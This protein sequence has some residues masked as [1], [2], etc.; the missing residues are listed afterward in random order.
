MKLRTAKRER[1][2]M[3]LSEDRK[4]DA[5][6][7]ESVGITRKTLHKWKQRPEFSARVEDLTRIWSERALKKGLARRE[8]RLAVLEDQH[9]RLLAVIEA[10]AADPDMQTIPGGSTGL[11]FRTYKGLGSGEHARIVE[12]YAVDVATIRELRGIQEQFA[13]ELGQVV[14]KV[15]VTTRKPYQTTEELE[16]EL[17]LLLAKRQARRPEDAPC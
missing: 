4:T 7:A 12:E 3:M 13:K 9:N 16:T 2:A 8:R 1:A 10:R 14:D 11:L 6:I 5:E 15:E 17:A